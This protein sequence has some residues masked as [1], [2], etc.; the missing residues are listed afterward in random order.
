MNR[1]VRL[2][3]VLCLAAAGCGTVSE[4]YRPQVVGPLPPT[5]ACNGVFLQLRAPADLVQIG[6]PAAF[7][8][9]VR[10]TGE[11]SIWMPKKPQ[12][13]FFWTYPNGRHDC[14]MIERED[15]RFFKT[16]ECRLLKPGEE[17]QLPGLVETAYFS[18]PGITEFLAEIHV[19]KNTNP[20]MAPFWSGRLLSN[21]YGLQLVPFKNV[22]GAR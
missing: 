11:R 21:A 2:L 19:A 16:T 18:R 4:I 20:E 12:Q 6:H 14:Y 10:N 9:T 5:E 17:L 1:T 13:G 22:S 7:N 15:T 8:V 3:S